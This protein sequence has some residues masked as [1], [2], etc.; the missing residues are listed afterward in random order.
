MEH[1]VATDYDRLRDLVRLI[2]CQV[3]AVHQLSPPMIKMFPSLKHREPHGYEDSNA[4][5]VSV[6]SRVAEPAKDR[7]VAQY[8]VLTL[9]E[10][11]LFLVA[12]PCRPKVVP[13]DINSQERSDS[14]RAFRTARE[15]GHSGIGVELLSNKRYSTFR[16]LDRD[17]T[18]QSSPYTRFYTRNLPTGT[19]YVRHKGPPHE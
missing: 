13:G 11:C 18:Q 3:D 19:Q 15:N 5:G 12:F 6:V 17:N 10:E 14:R 1:L 4:G 8:L 9:Q 2:S 16:R 7:G